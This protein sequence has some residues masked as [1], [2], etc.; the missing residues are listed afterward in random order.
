MLPRTVIRIFSPQVDW[1]SD[2]QGHVPVLSEDFVEAVC[3]DPDGFYVDATFG[4]GGHSRAILDKLSCKGRLLG[5]D[6]DPAVAELGDQLAMEDCRF[7]LEHAS[8]SELQE[9]VKRFG[10][11]RVAGV[12]F[13]LGVSSMQLD[14]SERGFSFQKSGPLDMR[15][16]Y[17]RGKPLSVCLR[18]I[19][20][21]KLAC[22]LRKF[23]D[24]RYAMRIAR[25]ILSTSREGELMTTTDLENVIFHALPRSSRYGRAHP[26]TRTFQ[27][28]RIWIND[29]FDQLRVG[30]HTAIN[31]LP[32][33][34]RLAVI[35]FH[36]GEDRR[37]RDWIE[38]RVHPCICPPDFPV[39]ACGRKASMRWIQKKPIR[40]SEEEV[41]NNPRARS[42]ML[43]VAERLP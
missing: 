4:A 30:I 32:P 41:N 25:A 22:I 33:G 34:G 12:G 28:L 19:D 3:T 1:T 20:E 2:V 35:S 21:K 38:S 7:H 13:D 42:A 8:F 14:Q 37:V 5:L 31:L 9:A 23:G 36:S 17:S 39:C 29:E 15:M 26:A 10:G 43:R 16:D 27:A 6:R 11:D 24:E 18:K 40:P